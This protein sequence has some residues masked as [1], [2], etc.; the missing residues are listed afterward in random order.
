MH[1]VFSE[2]RSIADSYAE[3]HARRITHCTVLGGGS[4]LFP[5]EGASI[6]GFDITRVQPFSNIKTPMILEDS[7]RRAGP[8]FA[9]AVG[10]ALRAL[11]G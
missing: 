8:R 3:K 1:E 6:H 7:I 10:L 9:V 11:N 5:G 2:A 4:Y